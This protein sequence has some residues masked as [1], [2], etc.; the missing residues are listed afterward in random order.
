MEEE[1]D[2]VAPDLIPAEDSVETSYLSSEAESTDSEDLKHLKDRI[3]AIPVLEEE[4][5]Y[6][7]RGRMVMHVEKTD[8][9]PPVPPHRCPLIDVTLSNVP[10]RTNLS[11]TPPLSPDGTSMP[12]SILKKRN[13]NEP[14]PMNQFGR[15]VPPEKP[16]RKSLPPYEDSNLTIFDR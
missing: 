11:P 6:H 12:R 5:T 10:D 14:I 9:P 8:A 1:Y 15:P 4:E 2:E 13:D 7:P 16:I 3:M